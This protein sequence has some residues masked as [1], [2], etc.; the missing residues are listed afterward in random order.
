VREHYI[1]GYPIA[2]RPWLPGQ[3]LGENVGNMLLY[4]FVVMEHDYKLVNNIS[5]V[6]SP[7]YKYRC[8]E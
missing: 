7:T 3:R 4:T 6:Q 8:L 5:M 1:L 2:M